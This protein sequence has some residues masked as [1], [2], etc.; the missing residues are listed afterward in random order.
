MQVEIQMSHVIPMAW[1]QEGKTGQ[2]AEAG[3][4][5][6]KFYGSLTYPLLDML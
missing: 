4:T 6:A 1:L 5:V 2:K 3:S